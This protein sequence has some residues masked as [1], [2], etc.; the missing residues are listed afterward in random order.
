M[1]LPSP[2]QSGRPAPLRSNFRAAWL[3]ELPSRRA[4]CRMASARSSS[5]PLTISCFI[6]RISMAHLVRCRESPYRPG[7]R[8]SKEA[9]VP[10]SVT[11]PTLRHA[12]SRASTVIYCD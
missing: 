10:D 6:L 2:W 9:G 3:R 5:K 12:V 11:S 4:S 8:R 7:A 1:F